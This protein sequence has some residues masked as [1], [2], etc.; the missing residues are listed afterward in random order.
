MHLLSLFWVFWGV[1]FGLLSFSSSVLAAQRPVWDETLTFL[2]RSVWTGATVAGRG[3]GTSD[4]VPLGK[5][6]NFSFLL[7]ASPPAR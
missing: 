2:V 6:L 3:S 7:K 5:G 1:L 4:R